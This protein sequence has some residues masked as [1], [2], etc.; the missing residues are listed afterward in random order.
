MTLVSYFA[1]IGLPGIGLFILLENI[2]VPLPTETAYIVAQALITSHR[3]NYL[4]VIIV[5]Q[6]AHFI[7][8]WTSYELGFRFRHS[9]RVRDVEP[10]VSQIQT[11]F[12][13][14][15]TKYGLAAVFFSRLIGYVRP[16]A[17]YIAGAAEIPRNSFLLWSFLGSLTFNVIALSVTRSIVHLWQRYPSTRFAMTTFFFLGV[18][19]LIA[20][21][22]SHRPKKEQSL[23]IAK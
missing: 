22:V 12:N 16:W 4:Q 19:A 20:W 23:P 5:F 1:Q 3:V 8:S 6:L 9:Q 7:G 18:I 13:G 17:S 15:L 11:L 14:W 2:G 21:E 10:K